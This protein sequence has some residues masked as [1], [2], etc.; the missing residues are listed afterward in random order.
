LVGESVGDAVGEAVD[1]P[2]SKHE[3]PS[4]HSKRA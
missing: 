3:T 2:E 1:T 4:R